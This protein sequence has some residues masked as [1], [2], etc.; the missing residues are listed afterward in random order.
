MAELSALE[1]PETF[2]AEQPIDLVKRLA[3]VGEAWAEDDS[4]RRH[5]SPATFSLL[6]DFPEIPRRLARLYRDPLLNE[7][8]SLTETRNYN[9]YA[10]AMESIIALK[11]A[12]IRSGLVPGKIVDEGCADGAL[13][14]KIA[15]DFP[16]SDLIGID[17]A[18]EF[19]ARCQERQRGGEFGGS[20]VYFH[21]RNLL[22]AIFEPGT[23]DTTLCNSTLHELW[24][25]GDRNTTVH[26]YLANK[27]AQSAKGGRLVIRD[28][29]GFDDKERTVFLALNREDGANE[30][31]F[32]DFEDATALAAYLR[33]LS[34]HARFFRFSRDFLAAMRA[35]GLRGPETAVRFE[36]A[37]V[38]GRQGVR[39]S[40]RQ[41]MEFITKKDYA[42]NWDAE[43]NEEFC[44][45]SFD[46]WKRA[47]ETAGFSIV[48][49]PNAPETGSRAYT[50][51]WRVEH[52]F[53]GKA[54]LY[55]ETAEGLVPLDY[56]A[57]NMVLI[58]E[59]R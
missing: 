4:L 20:F 43:M 33:G 27:F 14:V 54:T 38:D 51:E 24:S 42:D 52:N 30:D 2:F 7:Q 57:T 39:V 22:E 12:E 58:G 47:L 11:Y 40:L 34:T 56:P 45:W 50:S 17:I 25:Y 5:L 26:A 41:A 46:E 32:K 23:I 59:R 28:V 48:E 3:E 53:R 16:D 35:R 8:G 13:L 1:G 18:A 6:S 21:Q 31:P 55:E 49:N 9:T 15:A 10:R 29:V 37:T 36:E 44:F 19:L